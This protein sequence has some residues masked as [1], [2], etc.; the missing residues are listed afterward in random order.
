M[1]SPPS[2]EPGARR[3]LPR[4]Q[5][6]VVQD[7]G[8]ATRRPRSKEPHPKPKCPSSAGL[9]RICTTYY[10]SEPEDAAMIAG[11]MGTGRLGQRCAESRDVGFVSRECNIR[12]VDKLRNWIVVGDSQFAESNKVD[13]IVRDEY[14][15]LSQC[16]HKNIAVPGT[17]QG[18]GGRSCGAAYATGA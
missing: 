13:D 10:W 18:F 7:D 5:N 12:R 11:R 2:P 6:G 9:A 4:V 17:S 14:S 8:R 15:A 3:S 1:D 16:G